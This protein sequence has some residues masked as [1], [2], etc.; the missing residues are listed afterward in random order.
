MTLLTAELRE[1]WSA[2]EPLLTVRTNDEYDRAVEHLNELLDEV[3]ADEEHPLYELLDTLGTLIAAYEAEHMP[4]PA[5]TGA[6]LLAFLLEEH[7]LRQSDL[8]EIG[9]Q[10]VVSEILAGKRELNVRQIRA[11][12]TRFGL[13]PAAFV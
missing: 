6:Q 10:G 4:L 1:H 13:P 11:L 2:L 7:G 12:A 8:P 3:G 9:S 5:A